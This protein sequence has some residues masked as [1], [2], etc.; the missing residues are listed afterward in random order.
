MSVDRHTGEVATSTDDPGPI[1]S[2]TATERFVVRSAAALLGTVAIGL[3]FGLLTALVRTRW[4]PLQAADQAVSDSLVGVVAQH[5]MLRQVLLGVTNVGATA[6]LV[7]V[8]AVGALWLFLRGLPRLAVYVL[9]TGAGGLI[10]NAVVKALVGR[11]RPVVETPVHSV[12]GWSF[13]SGHAMSSLVCFGVVALVFIPIQRPGVRRVLIAST[14][15]LVTAIGFSRVALGVHYLTDVLAGWLLGS[16]WLILTAVA[17]HRWRRDTGI[18]A[19]PL[20][21]DV[22]PE[23]EDD[24]RPVPLRHPRA[25]EHPWRGVGEIAV[26]WVLLVGLIL[27]IGLSIRALEANTSVLRWDHQVVAMLADHRTSTL[28]SV[29]VVFG[30]LG[31][32]V[33]IIVGALV[34]AALAL[35]VF[36]SWRPVLFL[37]VALFGEI[38][39][40]LT[41]AA[42]VDRDRPRVAHLNPDLPPT[43]SFPSGHVAASL[44]LYA[45]TAA[46]VWAGTRR[47]QYR[48]VAAAAL[49]IPVM[50]GVQRLYAGAHHPTDLFGAVVL[51]SMWTAIAWWVIKPVAATP[52]TRTGSGTPHPKVTSDAT[53]TDVR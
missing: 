53:T 13:P 50:V 1:G 34:V 49:L 45:G 8:L 9:L 36:R 14:T 25:S 52:D 3:G 12:G 41:T 32:T 15:L 20:P 30:E 28:T 35:A 22:P 48:L 42:I 2:D 26:A 6:V 47:W 5:R 23:S 10:L 11:L 44:T 38:T 37:A 43:A 24:L 31:D 29:L 27:G 16:L 21:G 19:G 7:S 51:A 4:E 33:A 46:L 39:L 40:F 17:F 18:D